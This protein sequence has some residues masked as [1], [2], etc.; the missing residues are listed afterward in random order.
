MKSFLTILFA[1][2]AIVVAPLAAHSM[3]NGV[4][5]TQFSYIPINTPGDADGG[6]GFIPLQSTQDAPAECP[7]ISV[8]EFMAHVGDVDT[9]IHGF[10]VVTGKAFQDF[11][12][13]P[14][15]QAFLT[16]YAINLPEEITGM[17]WVDASLTDM[18]D[19]SQA[20]MVYFF[21]A[22]GC[23]GYWSGYINKDAIDN[24]LDHPVTAAEKPAE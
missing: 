17:E 11:K 14:D 13:D 8:A 2:L 3:I 12:T 18:E 5:H 1:S 9:G 21:T 6:K 20:Y 7:V 15:F 10:N 23:T 24:G 22:D 4:P 16:K 19:G